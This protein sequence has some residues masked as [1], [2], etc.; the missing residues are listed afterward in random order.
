MA[1]RKKVV[2]IGGGYAGIS[3]IR[4]LK[5]R[6][7]IELVL[8]DK[9]SYHNMQPEVY[10]FIANKI[11]AA[12]LTI[13]LINLCNGFDRA[14]KFYNRR[15]ENIDFTK[16][17]VFTE[18]GGEFAYDYLILAV[19]ARTLFPR[20]IEG[21][22]HTDDLKKLHKA[23]NFK[24]KFEVEIFNKI[25]NEGRMCDVL[26][27]VVI[28]AG[29]SGVEIAA[30]MAYYAK[31]FFKKGSFACDYMKIFLIG[32]TPTVLP[33]MDEFLI[34]KCETR[35]EE[36]KV[37]IITGRFVT[38]IDDDYIY[39]DD[40][41]KIRYSFSIFA[42]GIEAA[43]LVNKIE[44]VKKNRIGQLIVDR[45]LHV[46]GLKCVYAVGDVI[47]AR[48]KNDQL[49]PATVQTAIQT[50]K[51]AAVN[52]KNSID[53]KEPKPYNVTAPGVMVA[54]GGKYAAGVIYDKIKVSG[55]I[56]YLLKHLIFFKYKK[57]LEQIARRGYRKFFKYVESD[58]IS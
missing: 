16:R 22:S 46:E 51:A 36:L 25:D 18:E 47:E 40:G 54:L 34:Q 41:N 6:D 2:V 53:G 37:E 43:N 14:F 23:L 29:L 56:A 42:G 1:A 35:L 57:P 49:M 21:L 8:I 12:D 44:N 24:Q 52:I 11:D 38:K 17:M 19:G 13:D 3:A 5:D 33:G 20:Q 10:D 58:Q 4:E 15:V 50:G 30:E 7:D 32:A 9:H 26:N 31:Y 39:T 27:I 55:F 48:N 45:F 28:G